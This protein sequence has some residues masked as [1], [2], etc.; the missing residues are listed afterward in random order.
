MLGWCAVG[1]CCWGVVAREVGLG[2][3]GSVVL[4][5]EG[6]G[7]GDGWFWGVALLEPVAV[8]VFYA[9]FCL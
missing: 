1:V 7:W 3:G 4:F 5:V 9:V 6:L 8:R 2:W